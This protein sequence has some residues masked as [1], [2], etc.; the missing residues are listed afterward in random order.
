MARQRCPIGFMPVIA[1][2]PDHRSKHVDADCIRAIGEI[3]RRR[4]WA[5]GERDYAAGLFRARD[6][7]ILSET[8]ELEDRECILFERQEKKDM[9]WQLSHDYL[10]LCVRLVPPEGGGGSTAAAAWWYG[11]LGM[12]QDVRILARQFN[13]YPHQGT[14][15]NVDEPPH[16][17]MRVRTF[18]LLIKGLLDACKLDGADAQRTALVRVG[19]RCGRDFA[20]ELNN[21]F[22]REGAA[23]SFSER[24]ER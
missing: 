21:T 16:V 7:V 1:R 24:T 6:F 9:F 23:A 10:G 22:R 13:S 20:A 5:D 8:R 15:L 11:Q 12:R 18:H 19:F 2:V 17:A 3:W 14:L 4:H